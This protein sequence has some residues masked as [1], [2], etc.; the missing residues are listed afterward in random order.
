MTAVVT[1]VGCDSG[2]TSRFG[3]CAMV[4]DMDKSFFFLFL[5]LPVVLLVVAMFDNVGGMGT[6]FVDGLLDDFIKS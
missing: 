2:M 3:K 1:R 4:V 6:N 5:L